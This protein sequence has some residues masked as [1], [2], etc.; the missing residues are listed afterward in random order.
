[1]QFIDVRD[2][3]EW[4][5]LCVERR[6]TGVFNATNEGAPWSELLVGAD[7]TWVSSEHLAEHGVG[8]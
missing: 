3:A 7:V 1:M 5:V 8:E 6:V 4:L 2:L